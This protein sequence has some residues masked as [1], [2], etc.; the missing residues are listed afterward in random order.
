M[1][2]RVSKILPKIISKI[3]DWIFPSTPTVLEIEQLST[4]EFRRRVPPPAEMHL[5]A[6]RDA[7]IATMAIADYHHPLARQAVWEL[8]YRGNDA[9]ARLFAALAAEEIE[10]I[11]HYSPKKITIIPLPNSAARRRERGWNQ[12]ELI[13]R[14]IPDHAR[15]VSI[16][17]DI[18]KKIKNTPTQASLTKR[19]RLN[20]LAGCFYADKKSREKIN[21]DT[22]ILLLDDVTTTGATFAEALKPLNALGFTDICC[23]AVAH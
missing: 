22:L 10:K 6:L 20:N 5:P 19:K 17:T 12:T 13:A 1:H 7:P 2:S 11:A 16:R 8:K 21:T 4:A 3:L 15:D 14:Y 18:L 9:V 23:L